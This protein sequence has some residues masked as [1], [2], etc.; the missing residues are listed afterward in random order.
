MVKTN[1]SEEAISPVIS[2]VLIIAVVV[3]LAAIVGTV[4]L[5]TIGGTQGNSKSV[6]LTASKGSSGIAFTV[7]G[8]MD[9]KSVSSLD[10]VSGTS[11]TNCTGS[12]PKIGDG[13]TG[14]TDR[15]GRT[16]MVATFADGSKQ[17]V[18]D[19]NWGAVSGSLVGSDYLVFAITGGP[20]VSGGPPTYTYTAT[21]AKGPKWDEIDSIQI[22]DGVQDLPNTPDQA[23]SLVVDGKMVSVYQFTKYHVVAHLKD[24]S[25]VTINDQTFT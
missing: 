6:L 14:S 4:A 2:I 25:A 17:V 18:Y 9:L 13:C 20:S 22:D 3:I 23:A 24:G 7:Q 16:V 1:W 12:A 8:G 21:F 11:I 19:K 10:L 5:G 15:N